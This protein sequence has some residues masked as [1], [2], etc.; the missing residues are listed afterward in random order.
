MSEEKIMVEVPCG[1]IYRCYRNP[2]VDEKP[3]QGII[4]WHNKRDGFL[5]YWLREKWNRAI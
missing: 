2:L 3:K 1:N 4:W 5:W